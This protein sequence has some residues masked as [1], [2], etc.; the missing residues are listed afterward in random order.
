MTRLRHSTAGS[1]GDVNQN[2][3]VAS[4]SKNLRLKARPAW[5]SVAVAL[6]LLAVFIYLQTWLPLQTAVQIGADEGFELA[7]A[8]SCLHGNR[9][10]TE[11]WND[12]PPL[13]TWIVTEAL[14]HLSHSILIP[15]LVTSVFTLVLL[16]VLG[17]ICRR[18]S[19]L[20]TATLATSR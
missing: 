3:G 10:Y 15:R 4:E 11:V 8:T 19:G 1:R 18:I 5:R 7:K 14:R 9:L 20:V 17:T 6:T 13:H 2:R 16:A 12:Q